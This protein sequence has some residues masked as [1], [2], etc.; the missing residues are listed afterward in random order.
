MSDWV[1]LPQPRTRNTKRP[2]TG[3][4]GRL[5]AEPRFPMSWRPRLRVPNR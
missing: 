1:P 5:F 4:C 3:P 2:I